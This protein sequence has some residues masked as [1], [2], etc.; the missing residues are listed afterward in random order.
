[1]SAYPDTLAQAHVKGPSAI[2][3]YLQAFRA[4][5]QYLEE[6]TPEMKNADK[7]LLP[8]PWHIGGIANP[9]GNDFTGL[10]VALLDPVCDLMLDLLEL[11]THDAGEVVDVLQNYT[12]IDNRALPRA[13]PQGLLVVGADWK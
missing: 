6:I 8:T 4:A 13:G 11:A 2:H 7:D 5:D 12:R 1:M 3:D 9:G 10:T